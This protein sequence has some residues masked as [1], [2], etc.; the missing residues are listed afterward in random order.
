[1]KRRYSCT[2][3]FISPLFEKGKARDLFAAFLAEAQ[4]VVMGITPGS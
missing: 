1:M 2:F 3:A 4:G